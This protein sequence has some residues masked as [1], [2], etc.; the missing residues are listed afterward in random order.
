M[1]VKQEIIASIA[2]G[3]T[4]SVLGVRLAKQHSYYL[5]TN[6][7]YKYVK[8]IKSEAMLMTLTA[9]VRSLEAKAAKSA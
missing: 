2:K 7:Y 4:L 1:N 6:M 3:E 9:K 5:I 8:E